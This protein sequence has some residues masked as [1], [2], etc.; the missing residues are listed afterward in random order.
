M[1][2]TGKG[3]SMMGADPTEIAF[4]LKYAFTYIIDLLMVALL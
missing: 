1:L 4:T 3:K 2:T